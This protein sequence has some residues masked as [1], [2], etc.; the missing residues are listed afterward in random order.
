VYNKYGHT[1]VNDIAP[2]IF[3]TA[4]EYN[5]IINHFKKPQPPPSKVNYGLEKAP[6]KGN[7]VFKQQKVKILAEK[8]VDKALNATHSKFQ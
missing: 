6:E 8:I 1:G 2:K 4:E 7:D 5:R 3:S